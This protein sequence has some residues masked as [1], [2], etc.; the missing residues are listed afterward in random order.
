MS[1]AFTRCRSVVFAAVDADAAGA[2]E[3][4]D[5]AA[6]GELAGCAAGLAS[7]AAGDGAG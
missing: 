5:A 2:A 6:A 1:A 7:I 3:D 4:V